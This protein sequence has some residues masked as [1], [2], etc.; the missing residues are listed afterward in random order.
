M[1]DPTYYTQR[2]ERLLPGEN[3]TETDLCIPRFHAVDGLRGEDLIQVEMVEIIT[4]GDRLSRPIQRV[5]EEHRLRWPRQY[6]AFKDGIET[7]T[8]GTAIAT[9]QV[10][11]WQTQ[12]DLRALGFQTIEQLAT[13]HDGQMAGVPN[14]QV[15]RRK[16]QEFVKQNTK[17]SDTQSE[18]AALKEQMA[19]LTA[20]LA[21]QEQ[22]KTDVLS[23]PGQ[24]DVPRKRGWPKG[25]SRA[26]KAGGADGSD[27]EP[28][29]M[30][31]G[32][33]ST[34]VT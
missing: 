7:G 10:L 17:V 1:A 12:N 31:G 23:E 15:W 26:R 33:P 19:A 16:A 28:G 5:S 29:S 24:G 20:R 25:K 13:A 27:P 9:W 2:E 30:G 18:L 21:T 4:P 22:G 14:G 34:P 8:A 11:S 32:K 6:K 3:P